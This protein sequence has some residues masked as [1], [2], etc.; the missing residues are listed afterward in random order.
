M[1]ETARTCSFWFFSICHF[2]FTNFGW[3]PFSEKPIQLQGSLHLICI[4]NRLHKRA[5]SES[6]NKANAKGLF[7]L[8]PDLPIQQKPGYLEFLKVSFSYCS[9][10]LQAYHIEQEIAR[11]RTQFYAKKKHISL[12]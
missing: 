1:F 3:R 11:D 8:C 6:E 12:S 4:I 2:L 9:I 7:W 10:L 5:T